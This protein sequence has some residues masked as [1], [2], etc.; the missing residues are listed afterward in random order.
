M[1]RFLLD[2]EVP[3]GTFSLSGE[4]ALT[5]IINGMPNDI[6]TLALDQIIVKDHQTKNTKYYLANLTNKRWK[7]LCIA[8]NSF[9]GETLAKDPLEVM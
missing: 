5:H 3:V 8:R 2:K 1:V 6:S 4:T 9:K 7:R